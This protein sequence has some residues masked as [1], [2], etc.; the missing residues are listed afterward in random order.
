MS[1]CVLCNVCF[2]PFV[3]SNGLLP[4]MQCEV[5]ERE[6]GIEEESAGGK[7][8][9]RS[10][11]GSS[12]FDLYRVSYIRGC[13]DPK[14]MCAFFS[15][16]PSPRPSS[17]RNRVRSCMCDAPSST[18][19]FPL[20]AP[21]SSQC[22]I[23]GVALHSRARWNFLLGVSRWGQ[24]LQSYLALQRITITNSSLLHRNEAEQLLSLSRKMMRCQLLPSRVLDRALRAKRFLCGALVAA[25]L[26]ELTCRAQHPHP[27]IGDF[28]CLEREGLLHSLHAM[29]EYS[30][31]TLPFMKQWALCP[32]LSVGASLGDLHSPERI[33]F[34][35]VPRALTKQ[36]LFSC[37]TCSSKALRDTETCGDSLAAIVAVHSPFS[38][39]VALK[40]F[41]A[42]LRGRTGIVPTPHSVEACASAAFA[43]CLELAGSRATP[44]V[45]DFLYKCVCYHDDEESPPLAVLESALWVLQLAHEATAGPWS[46]DIVSVLLQAAS[47]T[48]LHN[49]TMPSAS[50]GPQP[51]W[52]LHS[53]LAAPQSRDA[54][55]EGLSPRA[56]CSVIRALRRSWVSEAQ[57]TEDTNSVLEAIIRQIQERALQAAAPLAFCDWHLLLEVLLTAGHHKLHIAAAGP[58]L[59]ALSRLLSQCSARAP[60]QSSPFPDPA[61]FIQVVTAATEM[62]EKGDL[63]CADESV[64]LA[65]VADCLVRG[66]I[67]L[68]KELAG[69]EQKPLLKLSALAVQRGHVRFALDVV[70]FVDRNSTLALAECEDAML[71][72]L[73]V[74][75]LTVQSPYAQ[76]IKALRDQHKRVFGP[77]VR[78]K[79]VCPP[80][81]A[82]PSPYGFGHA[83]AHAASIPHD[84]RRGTSYGPSLLP[85]GTL[86]S[87]GPTRARSAAW[88]MPSCLARL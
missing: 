24:P 62:L 4:S 75:A 53:I 9:Q 50:V 65:C 13:Y 37:V 8:R 34:P 16:A 14:P 49:A 79:R 26:R 59:G 54:L 66:G 33:G 88:L 20:F 85:N 25:W 63:A 40:H 84:E 15:A 78:A 68:S 11:F 39:I 64:L 77:L 44:S 45:G 80:P 73:L 12:F 29:C 35:S 60:H 7:V 27:F 47:I 52:T 3:S 42:A 43:C 10:G 18:V 30:G 23:I 67:C 5:L 82:P 31:S 28:G 74:G 61:L 32:A 21:S 51:C 71:E 72:A 86:D 55:H 36:L 57:P 56:Y 6:S 81:A 70:S 87:W 48:L 2:S 22:R 38:S 41:F 19:E 46:V 83:A 1:V 69:K 17:A 76:R 58:A